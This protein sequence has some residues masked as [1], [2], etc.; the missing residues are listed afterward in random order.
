MQTD[1]QPNIDAGRPTAFSHRAPVT[2]LFALIVFAVRQTLTWF[3]EAMSGPI[4][5]ARDTLAGR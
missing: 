3:V 2:P 5:A 4:D 1:A